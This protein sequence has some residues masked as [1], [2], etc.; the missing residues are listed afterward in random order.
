MA[1]ASIQKALLVILALTATTPTSATNPPRR[2]L[3]AP[4]AAAESV[5]REIGAHALDGCSLKFDNF[6]HV[7]WPAVRAGYVT[8]EAASF[9]TEGMLRG[10]KAGVQEHLLRSR[11]R[12]HRWFPNYPAAIEFRDA[13]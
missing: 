11:M 5:V 13:G 9:V 7:L 1:G 3:L 6:M 12:G 2:E 10:F 8:H 4:I